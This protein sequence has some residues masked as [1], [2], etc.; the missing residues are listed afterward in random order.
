MERSTLRLGLAAALLVAAPG[1]LGAQG[2]MV[3]EHGTC[4]MGRAGVGVSK[5][6]NDGS[7]IFYN[8]AGIAR[9]SGITVSAG[10][11]GILAM[12]SFA[13]DYTG[14]VTDLQ[15]SWIP[16]PHLYATYGLSDRLSAG[17]GVFVPYGLG[18]EWQ[19]E[20]GGE[21]VVP[22][23]FEGRFLGYSSTLQSI[24]VQ[25]TVA[26]AINDMIAIGVGFDVV[27]GALE[28]NQRLDFAE[29]AAPAP[30][31]TGTSLAQL[32]IPYGTDFANGTLE[33]SG[34]M[35]YGGHVGIWVRLTDALHLGARYL[36][37][38]KLDYEGTATFDPVPT[39]VVLPAGNPFGAPA[40]TPLDGVIT[41]LN[42]FS[43]GQL[44]DDQDVTASITM[45]D[46]LTVGASFSLTPSLTLMADWQW[47]HWAVFD[48]LVAD[49]E[50]APS[51]ALEELYEN[52]NALRI[53][54]E[55]EA[56]PLLTLRGGYL[57]HQGAAPDRTV[58]PLL[59]EGQRNEFTG[60]FGLHLTD[61]LSANVAY[62]Y[63]RQDKRRG[64][65]RSW[66]PGETVG[67]DI[68]GGLY[69]FNAH[70]VAATLTVHF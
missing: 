52:T 70:L 11:T 53:G 1:V 47:V 4:V 34:A 9:S 45:P 49:F 8:P 33:A 37:S 21:R 16:V 12:G 31:P 7:A 13:D 23:D 42:L 59:P 40:G 18:T 65:V 30:A 14:E 64:R 17:L 54:F 67:S 29:Q 46:Q 69:E 58:T 43:A 20:V 66:R 51:L 62:Q 60:G 61:M 38:V 44:L 35:G 39:G 2:F 10:V 19:P 25:P 56:N 26:Y 5:P 28:L 27:M 36:S 55:F 68:N 22:T 6:C 57:Y 24:Y 3:N 50:I 63:I 48:S 32:G 41:A 15:N